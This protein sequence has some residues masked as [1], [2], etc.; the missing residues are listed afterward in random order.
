MN[1]YQTYKEIPLLPK[2]L[3]EQQRKDKEH[4][5]WPLLPE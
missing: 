5:L 3:D 1:S 2:L 4:H